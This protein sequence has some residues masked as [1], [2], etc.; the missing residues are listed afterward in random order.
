MSLISKF[1]QNCK[2]CGKQISVGDTIS[3]LVDHWCSDENCAGKSIKDVKNQHNST[4]Y[5][6]NN[7]P[8]ETVETIET[9]LTAENKNFISSQTKVLYEINGTVRE[10]LKEFENDPNG[11]MIGQFTKIIYDEI[12]S[13]ITTS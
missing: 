13:R 7:P 10:T 8:A 11:A 9:N 3:K 6:K 4:M 2:A 5:E 12:Q 1:S